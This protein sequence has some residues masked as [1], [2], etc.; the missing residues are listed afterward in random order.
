MMHKVKQYKN[1]DENFSCTAYVRSA[2]RNA[3]N[4]LVCRVIISLGKGVYPQVG[5]MHWK[6]D[7]PHRS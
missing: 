7:D 2:W 3:I 6:V 5:N 4:L 1:E